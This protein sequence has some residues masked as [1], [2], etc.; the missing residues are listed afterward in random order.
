MQI[1][2]FPPAA[3][4]SFTSPRGAQAIQPTGQYSNDLKSIA[5]KRDNRFEQ[6]LGQIE[7]NMDLRFKRG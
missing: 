2:V 4:V 7:R 3:R 6:L 5:H 1:P